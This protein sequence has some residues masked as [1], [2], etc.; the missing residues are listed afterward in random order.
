MIPVAPVIPVALVALVV[1]V[2][3]VPAAGGPGWAHTIER[4]TVLWFGFFFFFCI[5]L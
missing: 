3:L 2:A 1:P 4:S 5:Q